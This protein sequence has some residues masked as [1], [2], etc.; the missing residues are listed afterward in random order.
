LCQILAQEFG[1]IR[2]SCGIWVH[3]IGACWQV[4]SFFL[5]RAGASAVKLFFAGDGHADSHISI[6]STSDRGEDLQALRTIS[7]MY[8]KMQ[9]YQTSV[10]RSNMSRKKHKLQGTLICLPYP[11]PSWPPNTR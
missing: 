5:F 10:Q 9:H 3:L 4:F 2:V 6:A 11:T 7:T 8:T 1:K